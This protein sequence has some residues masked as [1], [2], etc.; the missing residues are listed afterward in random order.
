MNSQLLC[1]SLTAVGNFDFHRAWNVLV[2][3]PKLRPFAQQAKRQGKQLLWRLSKVVFLWMA[4]QELC[5]TTSP[6]SEL[7][8]WGF[9]QYS[10]RV[11]SLKCDDSLEQLP[12]LNYMD[13]R[14][15][16]VRRWGGANSHSLT[17]KAN[18]YFWWA[19]TGCLC[20]HRML[21]SSPLPTRNVISRHKQMPS[22]SILV[23]LH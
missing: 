8:H 23:S 4:S 10:K 22:L 5:D 14:G 12:H 3:S 17:T 21:F 11:T 7:K 2:F 19:C 9:F 13:I 6:R 16:Q 1:Q 18:A 20:R 15:V